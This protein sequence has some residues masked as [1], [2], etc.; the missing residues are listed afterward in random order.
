[1]ALA[2]SK[3]VIEM[4][5]RVLGS[6]ARSEILKTVFI[7]PPSKP[8]LL[9]VPG[10]LTTAGILGLLLKYTFSRTIRGSAA[11]FGA[12]VNYW[13]AHQKQR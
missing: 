6:K 7:M 10:Y 9:W 12:S 5:R 13:R 8:K 11:I 3:T 2:D 1:V 4:S